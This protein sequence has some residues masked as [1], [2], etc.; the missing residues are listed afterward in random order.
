MMVIAASVHSY[1]WPTCNHNHKL[2]ASGSMEIL[3]VDRVEVTLVRISGRGLPKHQIRSKSE[4]L[5]VDGQTYV[6][7][8][9]WTHLSSNLLKHRW[10]MT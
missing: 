10:A 2:L 6:W 9:V 3:T 4:K 8:Y 1:L 7:T 5:I